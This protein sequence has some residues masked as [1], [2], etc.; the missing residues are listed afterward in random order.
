MKFPHSPYRLIYDRDCAFCT[1]SARLIQRWARGKL[2]ILP[3]Q[4]PGALELHPGLSRA[5]VARRVYLLSPDN[6]L[7]GGAEAV[8]R[9]AALNPYGGIALL[10]YFPL[11]R[12]LFD[13]L[14]DWVAR[15]RNLIGGCGDSCSLED[16]K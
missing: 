4:S 11:L 9:A 7:W 10:Y 15:N 1:R 16:R 8:A 6:R 3:S 2:E 14:Y 12:P 5:G 13:R